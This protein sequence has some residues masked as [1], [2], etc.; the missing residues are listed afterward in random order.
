MLIGWNVFWLVMSMLRW[1]VL[2]NQLINSYINFVIRFSINSLN[3][4]DN[5]QLV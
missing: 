5:N 1:L 3:D 4:K 2:L